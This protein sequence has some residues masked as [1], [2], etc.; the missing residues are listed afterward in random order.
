MKCKNSKFQVPNSKNGF[1]LLE[2][3]FAISLFSIVM[4]IVMGIFVNGSRTQRKI[5]ELDLVQREG[6][7]LIE[8]ISREV[9]MATDIDAT[10]WQGNNASVI[11]FANYSGHYVEYCRDDNN[12]DAFCDSSGEYISRLECAGGPTA[13]D[14]VG[15]TRKTVSSPDI[16]VENLKFYTPANFN[17]SQPLVTVSLRIK[18]AAASQ[19]NTEIS[20]QN[21]VALR[22]Y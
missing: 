1:T 18:P 22:V 15:E 13:G 19:Y 7:Y 8:S 2:M 11:G 9:R 20:L 17:V 14:C 6:N 16:K 21:T 5:A 12:G 4:V 3:L 10:N